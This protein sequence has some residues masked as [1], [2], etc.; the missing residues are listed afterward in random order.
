MK[1]S[2]CMVVSLYY[3]LKIK[4]TSQGWVWDSDSASSFKY[5]RLLKKLM[6]DGRTRATNLDA[7]Y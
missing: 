2:V 6:Q 3:V 5:E 7:H 1:T 4:V